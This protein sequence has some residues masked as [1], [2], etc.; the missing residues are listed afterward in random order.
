MKEGL[1]SQTREDRRVQMT[2]KLMLDLVAVQE[3]GFL[4]ESLPTSSGVFSLSGGSDILWSDQYVSMCTVQYWC[5]FVLDKLRKR[6]IKVDLNL[7]SSKSL[8]TW[9]IFVRS[10]QV[11]WTSKKWWAT[12][13]GERL[14]RDLE[15]L[16]RRFL[17]HRI[18][19][20]GQGSIA[21]VYAPN[22]QNLR[23]CRSF[24]LLLSRSKVSISKSDREWSCALLSVD[25]IVNEVWGRVS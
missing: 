5:K 7:D 6:V 25:C 2:V 13:E 4:T 20:G 14:P 16:G 9:Q 11:S 3:I 17:E 23:V 24:F 1:I 21:W 22:L 18:W 12:D 8:I 19:N 15:P 10:R